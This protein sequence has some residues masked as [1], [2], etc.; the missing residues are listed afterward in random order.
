MDYRHGA[1]AQLGSSILREPEQCPIVPVYVGTAPAHLAMGGSERVN[2]PVLIRSMDEGRALLGYDEDWTSYTLCEAMYAHFAATNRPVGPIV[3]INVLDPLAFK[4]AQ[5]TQVTDVTLTRA[6][7]VI[8][9]MQDAILDTIA[10]AGKSLGVDYAVSYVADTKSV[11]I[12]ALK[13]EL[14]GTKVTVS[15]YK[16]GAV[17]VTEAAV[18]GERSDLG[19]S[20][21][22]YAIDKV[23]QAVDRVPY[24]LVAPG[25]SQIPAVHDAMIAASQRISGHWYAWINADL[26]LRETAGSLG[27][28][29]V[30]AWQQD[31]GYTFEGGAPGWPKLRLSGRIYHY[32]TLIT[33]TQMITDMDVGGIPS[34][35]CDNKALP[36]DGIVLDGGKG[37]LFGPES[38]NQYLSSKGISSAVFWGGK[39]VAW[40][41]HTGA[42]Q[43]DAQVDPRAVYSS[44][45]RMLYYLVNRFQ[46]LYGAEIGQKYTRNRAQSIQASFQAYLD[47]LRTAGA[48]VKGEC[49]LSRPENGMDDVMA[50]E[51]VFD[52]ATTNTP[53]VRSLRAVVRYD[54][55]GLELIFGEEEGQ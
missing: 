7:A 38:L 53:P 54:E 9:G 4:A 20:T 50:G 34:E 39:W 46:L 48:L 30:A 36:M 45:M 16:L 3:L 44:N 31:N 17:T 52:I 6:G 14:V 35:S 22:V 40:G 2:M 11:R 33:L 8:E 41:P 12:R 21:G 13:N 55:T 25:W 43:A 27:L 32:S 28:D 23:Y 15:Y 24:T 5:A 10:I 18:I 49:S 19:A 26:P 51:M 47:G 42:F 37:A 29:A 1:Y